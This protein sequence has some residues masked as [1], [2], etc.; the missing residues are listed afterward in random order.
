MKKLTDKTSRNR[1][2]ILRRETITE[3]TR[4]QLGK[5]AGGA[6]LQG[7]GWPCGISRQDQLCS[8]DT[9]DTND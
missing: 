2:L 8:P 9:I 5:A 6:T 3:L 7:G 4:L 1:K